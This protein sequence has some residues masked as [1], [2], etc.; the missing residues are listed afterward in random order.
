MEEQNKTTVAKRQMGTIRSSQDSD[1]SPPQE[2]HLSLPTRKP[3]IQPATSNPLVQ[4]ASTN[5][6]MREQGRTYPAS[7]L[8]SDTA[9]RQCTPNFPA[10][11]LTNEASMKEL[12]TCLFLKLCSSQSNWNTKKQRKKASDYKYTKRIMDSPFQF[13]T[14]FQK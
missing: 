3:M 11:W 13:I 5:W 4:A 9:T 7:L 8:D 6:Q 14:N 12:H 2:C 1:T 10:R